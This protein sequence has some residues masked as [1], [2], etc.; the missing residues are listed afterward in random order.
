MREGKNN[1]LLDERL[2]N[3]DYIKI[4]KLVNSE[5][6]K[7]CFG[8]IS[9][10]RGLGT[11]NTLTSDVTQ[12]DIDRNNHKNREDSN[13]LLH[14]LLA[15]KFRVLEVKGSYEEEGIG[16]V[17][18]TSYFVYTV[19]GREEE[20]KEVLVELGKMFDQDAVMIIEGKNHTGELV[21]LREDTP[22]PE[23]VK[24]FN[25][26]KPHI[27]FDQ[28][29]MSKVFTR[30]GTK[31]HGRRFQLKELVEHHLNY[32]ITTLWAYDYDPYILKGR[33]MKDPKYLR[34]F[35]NNIKKRLDNL[36]EI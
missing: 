30:V 4:I 25:K 11:Q 28:D 24:R 12:Y 18:E 15:N 9:A 22:E 5:E 27:N 21:W 10:C 20:L 13:L 16:L 8:I 19:A 29:S 32:N 14:N 36:E 7:Y 35:E 1:N 26:S 34:E 33:K 6:P 31:K 17:Y 3:S 2:R 23:T